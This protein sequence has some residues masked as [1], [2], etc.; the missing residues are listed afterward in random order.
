M[1][2]S[3]AKLCPEFNMQRMAMQYAEESYLVAHRRFRN[4]SADRRGPGE[5]GR[6][7]AQ[8]S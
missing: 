1:K 2:T 3:I 8:K 4:L 6:G 7:L 5:R